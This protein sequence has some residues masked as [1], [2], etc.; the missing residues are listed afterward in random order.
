MGL[1]AQGFRRRVLDLGDADRER[2]ELATQAAKLSQQY[3]SSHTPIFTDNRGLKIVV[4]RELNENWI[5][6]A[7]EADTGGLPSSRDN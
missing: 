3:P 1:A 2:R 6:S 5:L 7:D 4:R